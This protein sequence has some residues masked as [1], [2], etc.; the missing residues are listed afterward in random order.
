MLTHRSCHDCGLRVRLSVTIHPPR[1]PACRLAHLPALLETRPCLAYPTL[2]PTSSSGRLCRCQR[3]HFSCYNYGNIFPACP[4]VSRCF[5]CRPTMSRSV[6]PST[7]FGD[8]FTTSFYPFVNSFQPS[9]SSP[10]KSRLSPPR[11]VR[12]AQRASQSPTSRLSVKDLASSARNTYLVSMPRISSQLR[13]LL[14]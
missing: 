7:D 9:N 3:T 12:R 10:R 2:L 6:P 11:L 4:G 13:P 14:L 5:R 8:L 1:C